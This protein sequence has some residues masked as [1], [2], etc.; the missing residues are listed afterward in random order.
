[1]WLQPQKYIYLGFIPE[2]SC[3]LRALRFIS[4]KDFPGKLLI[5]LN[6]CSYIESM[7]GFRRNK[8]IKL[9]LFPNK[10]CF[11]QAPAIKPTSNVIRKIFNPLN[12]NTFVKWRVK[13]DMHLDGGFISLP[14]G[15]PGTST[16]KSE[17]NIF[18]KK[19]ET[20]FKNITVLKSNK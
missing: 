8:S 17:I 19:I 7:R 1:M 11:L 9:G 4:P 12:L 5:Y 14:T 13:W 15:H 2:E 20:D 10:F 16:K 6:N 18:L 3:F